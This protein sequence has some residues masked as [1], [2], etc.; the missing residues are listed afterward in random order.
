MVVFHSY[1][2]TWRV[3]R[4]TRER[5]VCGHGVELGAPPVTWTMYSPENYLLYV[6]MSLYYTH[7]YNDTYT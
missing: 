5:L 2:V 6:I 7:I 4:Y 3:Y 1:V